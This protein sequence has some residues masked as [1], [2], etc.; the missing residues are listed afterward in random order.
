M[1]YLMLAQIDWCGK[2][3]KETTYVSNFSNLS[4]KKNEFTESETY[5]ALAI[6]NYKE[7]VNAENNFK[8]DQNEMS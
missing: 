3:V 4:F 7:R 2:I 1:C 8:R 6:V 5:F